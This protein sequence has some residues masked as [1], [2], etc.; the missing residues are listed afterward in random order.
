[1]RAALGV[2]RPTKHIKRSLFHCFRERRMRVAG[3]GDVLA[4]SAEGHDRGDLGQQIAGA[5]AD[6]RGA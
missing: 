3:A 2:Q 1:M 5:W 6:D 4:G